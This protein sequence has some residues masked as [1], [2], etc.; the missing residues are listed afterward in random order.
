MKRLILSIIILFTMLSIAFATG[1]PKKYIQI[2]VTVT[3]TASEIVSA[4][5]S[6]QDIFIQNNDSSGILYLDFSGTAT[7]SDTKVKLGPGDSINIENGINSV[8]A[9]GSIASNANV[10]IVLGR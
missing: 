10:S 2:T 5:L 9:I 7:V 8:S 1:T 6:G 3:S 4:V